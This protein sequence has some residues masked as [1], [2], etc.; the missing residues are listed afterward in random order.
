MESVNVIEHMSV[1]E[2]KSGDV[3]VVKVNQPISLQQE[4]LI[5]S[6]LKQAVDPHDEKDIRF[7]VLGEGMELGILNTPPPQKI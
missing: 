1:L 5:S 2:V 3:I 4:E 7:L 6:R